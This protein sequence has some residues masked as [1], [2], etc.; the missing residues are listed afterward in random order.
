MIESI[1]GPIQMA[2]EILVMDFIFGRLLCKRDHFLIRAV[3]SAI[4]CL[5][6]IVFGV[7]VYYRVTGR[8]FPYGDVADPDQSLFKFAFYLC[9]FILS[10]AAMGICYRNSFW[11]ILSFGSGG[12]A[13]QHFA[14]N[15]SALIRYY[16]FGA[17]AAEWIGYVLEF[18]VCALVFTAVY[19]GMVY[20][21][22]L[23]ETKRGTFSGLGAKALICVSVIVICIGISRITTDDATR[24]PLAFVAESIYAAVSCF[25]ILVILSGVLSKDVIQSDLDMMTELLHREREQYHLSK[26]NIELI[27]I[28]CHDLKHQIN[29]LRQG[30]SESRIREIEDA[31]M[32]YGCNAKTGNDALDV[33]LT[34]KSLYCERH[35]IV[36]NY[37]VDGAALAGMDD[38]DVYSFFGNALSNAIEAVS[39]IKDREL[40]FIAMNVYAKDGFLSVH[41]ENYCENKIA[42]ENGLPVTA[43]DKNYHGF[44]MKSMDHIA[45]K[46]GGVLQ[47]SLEGEKFRLDLLIP[48]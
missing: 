35:E 24:L 33:I 44:G 13:A 3:F 31:V 29:A 18:G 39:G 15:L 22:S 19:F 10:V 9:I 46:Y 1:L 41:V 21:K 43:K 48:I 20:K 16:F 7:V 34:E 14:K 26:E 37:F 45:K 25:L 17:D 30:T 36:L 8:S 32:I 12:Y 28:K 23:P 5:A 47:T 6:L 11:E 2:V 38:I 40:R 27:N 42:F 4:I